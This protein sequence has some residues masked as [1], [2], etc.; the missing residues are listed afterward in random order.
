MLKLNPCLTPAPYQ[1]ASNICALLLRMHTLDLRSLATTGTQEVRWRR[2]EDGHLINHRR[3]PF[4][5]LIGSPFLAH[6]QL[7]MKHGQMILAIRQRQ[8][9]SQ[10]HI[11]DT[12]LVS[13]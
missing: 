11:N 10:R 2:M 4:C 3:L 12:T 5:L 6:G 7:P 13:L 1:R 8:F 9:G